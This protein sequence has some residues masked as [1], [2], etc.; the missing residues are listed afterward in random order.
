MSQENVEAVRV[1]YDEWGRGNFRAGVELYDPLVLFI[2]IVE[3]PAADHYLGRDGVREFMLGMLEAWTGF[4]ITAEEFIEAGDS[5]VVATRWR[6]MGRTSG[7]LSERPCF[8]VWTF[9]GRAVTRLEFFGE[10]G[11]A[12]EAVGLPKQGAHADS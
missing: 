2:P 12:L 3:F 9:R 11:A 5:V 8:D 10:R 6:G 7:V 4:T 1:I